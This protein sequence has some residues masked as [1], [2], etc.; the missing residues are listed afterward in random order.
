MAWACVV[1]EESIDKW[2]D[3]ADILKVEPTVLSD[4]VEVKCGRTRGITDDPRV[5]ILL[6][7]YWGI[8]VQEREKGSGKQRAG[9]SVV[10]SR[11]GQELKAASSKNA[12]GAPCLTPYHASS[13][14][15]MTNFRTSIDLSAWNAMISCQC[16]RE[17]GSGLH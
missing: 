17:S 1:V 14:K 5:S 16:Q 12:P 9:L 8:S 7:I 4:D 13:M 6:S 3:A 2:S 10:A 11:P 15:P